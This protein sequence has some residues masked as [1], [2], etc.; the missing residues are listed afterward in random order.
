MLLGDASSQKRNRKGGILSAEFAVSHSLK[1]SDLVE[2]KAQAIEESFNVKLKVYY[3]NYEY[4]QF[5]G[6]KFTQRKRIRVIHDWFHRGSKKYISDKIRFM[7][8]SIGLAMLLCD[9]GS[10][11]R[12]KK[13]HKSGEIYFLA[14]SIT[15]ATHCF[16]EEEVTRLLLHIEN[17]CGAKGYINPERRFR[18]GEMKVYQRVNFNSENS[19]ILW[20]YVSAWIPRVPSMMKKFEFIIERYGL[21]TADS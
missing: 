2:W 10:I 18:K 21:K 3:R 17:M 15:I 4:S 5:A 11:R 6:F 14:P 8:H 20:D 16:S 1:Q 13:Q 12:R 19:K 9:D 7:N